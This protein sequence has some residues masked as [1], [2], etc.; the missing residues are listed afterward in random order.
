[1]VEVTETRGHRHTAAEMQLG[2][3]E[4]TGEDVMENK[5]GT[6]SVTD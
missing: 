6:S 3:I 4:G 1:M 2:W 5:T